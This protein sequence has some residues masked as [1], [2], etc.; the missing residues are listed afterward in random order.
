[1][2]S[3]QNFSLP[4][5]WRWGTISDLIRKDGVFVDGDWV[6]SKDQDPKGDVRLIQLADIGDGEYR[7]KSSRFLTKNKALGLGCTFL[8]PKDV[9][10]ARMPEPLGRSCVY[11][12]DSKPAVTVVDVCVIRSNN[13]DFNHYWLS[14]F[15][16]APH[17]RSA[18]ARLQAGSTRKRISRKNLATIPLP[19]PPLTDQ[20]Q[21]AGEIDRKFLQLDAGV[22]VL[23]RIQEKLKKYRA[24]VLKTACE[25]RLVPTEAEL[26]KKEGRPYETGAQLLARILTARRK[27]WQGRGQ[28]K[29]PSGPETTSLPSL[30]EGWSWATLP[31]LG[32][33]GRGK[34]KHRPRDDKRLYDG[35]YPFIQTGDIRKA[36]GTIRE[37]TQTYSEFGLQQ[38]RLWPA[39]TLC[40]TIAAN[41][42]E[43]GILTFDS[44]FPD[45]VVGFIHPENQTT[46]RYIE[47]FIRTAKEHL[48][49]FAPSTAQKNINLDVLENVAIPIP[50]L[51]EQTRIVAEIERRLS[52]ADELETLVATNFQRASRLRQSILQR[53]F[54]GK[55]VSDQP[56]KGSR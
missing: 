24:A 36:K 13:G 14:H 41:I 27:N 15:L 33:L 42:A 28:Y 34:S 32:V 25:G 46:T 29:E 10:V 55:S 50:P 40:I 9:L 21:I 12:G 56:S 49:R 22:E 54:S 2:T 48:E 37:F 19:I 26:A 20:A 52:G 6:E 38:S 17:F 47:F 30:P 23:H 51:A 11:P 18:V 4:R 8:K 43:T 44:C 7:D 3:L 35:A 16:N 5:N 53:A 31:I 39:G 45:S 1:M